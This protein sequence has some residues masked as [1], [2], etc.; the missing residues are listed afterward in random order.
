M[1]DVKSKSTKEQ[2][3]SRRI[4]GRVFVCQTEL[5]IYIYTLH[6]ECSLKVCIL[7]SSAPLKTR[8]PANLKQFM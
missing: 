7:T 1:K 8:N 6:S 5:K 3:S 2:S 4:I